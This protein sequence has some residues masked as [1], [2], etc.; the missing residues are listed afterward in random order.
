MSLAL[1]P[2]RRYVLL[3]CVT[4]GEGTLALSVSHRLFHDGVTDMSVPYKIPKPAPVMAGPVRRQPHCLD[5]AMV[6]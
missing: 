4:P 6:N 3:V 1:V 2:G 5:C